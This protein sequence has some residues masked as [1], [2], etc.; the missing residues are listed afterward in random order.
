M[1]TINSPMLYYVAKDDDHNKSAVF[2]FCQTRQALFY[3]LSK[4]LQE[5][6]E[7]KGKKMGWCVVCMYDHGC[8][9]GGF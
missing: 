3:V 7:R 6:K 1:L 8:L 5:G 9:L 4:K 2:A